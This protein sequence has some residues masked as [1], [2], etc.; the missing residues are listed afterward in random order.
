MN[1]VECLEKITSISRLKSQPG[2]MLSIP[3]TNSTGNETGELG[4]LDFI[5][6][7]VNIAG[8]SPF[9]GQFSKE[10]VVGNE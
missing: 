4:L 5:L 7:H 3:A 8:L 1:G 9:V 2:C 10:N 6:K